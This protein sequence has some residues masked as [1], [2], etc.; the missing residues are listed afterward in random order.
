MRKNLILL[1]LAA[2]PFASLPQTPFK[3]KG[4]VSGIGNGE[5]IFLSY[6]VDRKNTVDSTTL[7]NGQFLFEGQ[8]KNPTRANLYRKPKVKGKK[9]DALAFYIESKTINFETSDSLKNTKITGSYK[10]ITNKS[11]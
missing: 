10:S 11:S 2:V 7:Y 5:K 8:V 6:V 3:L 9:S 4:K 1:A